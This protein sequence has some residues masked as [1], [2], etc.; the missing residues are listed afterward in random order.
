M[1]NCKAGQRLRVATNKA[2]FMTY[3][4]RNKDAFFAALGPAKVRQGL[5]NGEFLGLTKASAE[6]WLREHGQRVM[7]FWTRAGVFVAALAIL[8]MLG[9]AILG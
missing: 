1:D 5:I 7:R 9:I 6:L 2:N 3:Q 8:A 4:P